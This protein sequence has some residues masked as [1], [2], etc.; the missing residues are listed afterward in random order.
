[1]QPASACSARL[2][3]AVSEVLGADRPARRG[4]PGPAVHAGTESTPHSHR[5]AQSALEEHVMKAAVVR[6]FG[7]PLVI[8]ERPDPEPG[9]G[10]QVRIRV[11][12]SG[13]CRD[14]A[15][16]H[17]QRLHRRS[18]RRTDQGPHRLRDVTRCH[19]PPAGFSAHGKTRPRQH[20]Q[21]GSSA[22][23][24]PV[25]R[26][27]ADRPCPCGAGSDFTSGA[28]APAEGGEAEVERSS[29][30]GPT[31]S[32][33]GGC[34]RG[35]GAVGTTADCRGGRLWEGSP[36]SG[37]G[38]KPRPCESPCFSLP[39]GCSRCPCHGGVGGWTRRWRPGC[40]GSGIGRIGC[41]RSDP[42]PR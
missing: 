4:R 40:S 8:E 11:E 22:A 16:A 29:R 17:R 41:G 32:V 42:M 6:S 5:T 2:K 15:P 20:S 14:P 38:S 35:G 28:P 39:S 9:P 33:I 24:G 34:D 19:E 12:A 10:R 23:S 3:R 36:R 27:V 25:T 31:A 30:T 21:G 7:Q 26:T 1:M 18:P 13:L 37:P